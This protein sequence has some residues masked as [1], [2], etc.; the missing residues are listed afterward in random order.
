MTFILLLQCFSVHRP[1]SVSAQ[2][3][4]LLCYIIEKYLCFILFTRRKK[5][6]DIKDEKKEK[7]Q[8]VQSFIFSTIFATSIS[9]NS[10]QKL[11]KKQS[12]VL[13]FL[14]FKYENSFYLI[15][16]FMTFIN[17]IF[18]IIHNICYYFCLS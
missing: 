10:N 9:P 2:G 14:S 8:G 1:S 13:C 7:F 18:F 11:K 12:H 5:A 17:T 6:Q 3:L 4:C 16:F 15:S